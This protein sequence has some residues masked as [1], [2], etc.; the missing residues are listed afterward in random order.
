MTTDWS[1]APELQSRAWSFVI[2]QQIHLRI[3]SVAVMV[4]LLHALRHS[5]NSMSRYPY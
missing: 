2:C 3:P 1:P 4:T 5:L